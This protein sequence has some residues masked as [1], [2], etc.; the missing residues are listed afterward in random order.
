MWIKR[1]T[2]PFNRLKLNIRFTILIGLVVFIPMSVFYVFVYRFAK[3]QQIEGAHRQMQGS[4]N[5]RA[6]VMENAFELC[7]LTTQSVVNNTSL[8]QYLTR[9]R[10]GEEIP[11][12]EIVDFKNNELIFYEKLINSNPSLENIRIYV[13]S[14]SMYEIMPTLYRKDRMRSFPWGNT[15]ES[16]KWEFDYPNKIS[17]ES[18]RLSGDHLMGLIT[19]LNDSEQRELAVVEVA[20]RMDT[21]YPEAFQCDDSQ[22]NAFVDNHGDVYG[23]GNTKSQWNA[24]AQDIIKRADGTDPDPQYIQTKLNGR[25]VLIGYYPLSNNLGALVELVNLQDEMDGLAGMALIYAAAFLTVFVVVVKIMGLIV[26]RLLRQYNYISNTVNLV[27]GGDL[28]ARVPVLYEDEEMGHLAIQINH[29]LQ[30]IQDLVREAVQSETLVKN[31][32]IRALQNQI[33]A[34]FIYN[35]LE[36]IKMMAEIDE[37]YVIA[38]SITTLGKLLRYSMRW[39]SRSVTVAEEVEYIKNYLELIN[40]R[41]DYEIYLSL[42]LPDEI[43]QQEI[44]KRSLQP[45]I[46][47][48]IVHGIEDIA[49]DTSIYMKGMLEDECCVIE[50]SDAGRGMS[51][52]QVEKLRAKIYG[53][54]DVDEVTSGS[55]NGIGLKNVQDRLQMFYGSEYGISIESQEN[56]YTK[57]IVKFPRKKVGK[58]YEINLNRGR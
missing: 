24:Q 27:S 52:E 58:T 32:E 2:K 47:N 41:F 42:N 15:Y 1:M 5:Q 9:M 40:L 11:V 49:E 34:H 21:A 43:Y 3:Y 45:I 23:G 16:G 55:G 6:I 51:R 19:T 56:C 48:A 31:S 8:E 26:N 25:H 28:S 46:E 38:D 44:P 18:M 10:D 54:V 7:M 17:L 13:D 29:M 20:I 50:I 39:T 37:K 30:R 22:W 14:D 53:D 36:S 12:L 35:V 57:V 33:N 4:L